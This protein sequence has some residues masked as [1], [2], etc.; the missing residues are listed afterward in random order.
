MNASRLSQIVYLFPQAHPEERPLF[1]LLAALLG[2]SP[3][4]QV[5][6]D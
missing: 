5:Q 6:A 4:A 1:Q 3:H 2:E